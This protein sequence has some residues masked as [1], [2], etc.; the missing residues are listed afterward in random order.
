MRLSVTLYAMVNKIKILHVKFTIRQWLENFHLVGPVEC[1][2]FITRIA[3]G[4]G[5]LNWAKFSYIEAPCFFID[6][7]YLVFGHTHICYL[8]YVSKEEGKKMHPVFCDILLYL[9]GSL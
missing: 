2:S 5:V 9:G 6:E 7:N 1:T 4:L 3:Q 8:L